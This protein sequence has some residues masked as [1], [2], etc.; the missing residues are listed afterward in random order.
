MTEFEALTLHNM[1]LYDTL[2]RKLQI[3]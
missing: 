3:T 2:N 1:W